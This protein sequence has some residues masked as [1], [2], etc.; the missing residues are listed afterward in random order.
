MSSPSVIEIAGI[1]PVL[2]RRSK[3]A[4]YVNISIKPFVGVRVSVP[5]SLS[6]H[7]AEGFVVS[8]TGWIQRHLARIKQIERE[9]ETA[10]N[11]YAGIDKT[12]AKRKLIC[13][14]D[15]LAGNHGFEYNKVFIRSQKTR[16]GSCSADNNISLNVMLV[17]LPDE[18][19]DYVILHEL[20]HTKAKNHGKDFWA[21]LDRFVENA[22]L[23]NSRLKRYRSE[24]L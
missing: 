16:W 17:R 20:I 12:E 11:I 14:L 22:K 10:S 19:I 13:R 15:E 4:R 5:Q 7:R 21:Y 2:F 8:K 3:R 9:Y 23:L 24:L 6:F 18:L 1:G